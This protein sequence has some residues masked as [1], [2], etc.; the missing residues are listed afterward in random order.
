MRI[1]FIV[2]EMLLKQQEVM[3]LLATIFAGGLMH[4]SEQQDDVWPSQNKLVPQSRVL[5]SFWTTM[6]ERKHISDQIP[7]A[8]KHISIFGNLLNKGKNGFQQ[9]FDG[10]E[11]ANIK[12]QQI[13]AVCQL[14]WAEYVSF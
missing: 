13:N 11:S 10:W 14:I 5:N 6:A 8:R 7:A 1:N 2:Y 3:D 12:K 9:K 4:V